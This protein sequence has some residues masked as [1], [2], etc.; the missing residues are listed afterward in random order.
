MLVAFALLQMATLAEDEKVPQPGEPA[1]KELIAARN[2]DNPGEIMKAEIALHKVYER[3]VLGKGKRESGAEW[4]YW[5]E[6]K[7]EK[8]LVRPIIRSVKPGG[9]MELAGLKAGDVIAA[10][11]DT[12]FDSRGSVPRLLALLENAK[13]GEPLAFTVMRGA[14]GRPF[15]ER[16]ETFTATVIPS[17]KLQASGQK[18]EPGQFD[19]WL[20]TLDRG[21]D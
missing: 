17:E 14:S 16:R 4:S 3:H 7:N 19:A 2:S 15:E 9:I 10:S 11:G 21:N 18:E 1:F 6:A 12:R 5:L 13:E 20:G 8:L